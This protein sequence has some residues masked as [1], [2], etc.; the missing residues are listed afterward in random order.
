VT[1]EQHRDLKKEKVF[2]IHETQKKLNACIV[3]ARSFAS[4]MERVGYGLRTHPDEVKGLPP[5]TSRR[6]EHDYSDDLRDFPSRQEIVE[7][8]DELRQWR[9]RLK[10][11]EEDLRLLE[12]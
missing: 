1:D 3:K 12:G 11:A 8:C 6:G 9:E 2:E 10:S 5:V 4:K 7:L